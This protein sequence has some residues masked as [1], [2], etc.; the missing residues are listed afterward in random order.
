MLFRSILLISLFTF[1]KNVNGQ[2]SVDSVCNEP[3]YVF[4]DEQAAS[5][6]G[7]LEVFR[8]W[9]HK[10]LFLPADDSI[11][12]HRLTLQFIVS[13]TGKIECTKILRPQGTRF[14]N[15]ALEL[16]KNSPIWTPAKMHGIPV[17]QQFV[18]VLTFT[19]E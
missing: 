12:Y 6:N 14:E 2:E 3:A 11:E 19:I 5:L 9:F 18:M 16:L 4:V 17:N 7:G 10:N 13:K 15:K 1:C 8:D